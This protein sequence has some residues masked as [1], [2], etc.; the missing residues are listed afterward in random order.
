LHALR[1]TERS[2]LVHKSDLLF[3]DLEYFERDDG[4]V[5]LIHPHTG[6]HNKVLLSEGVV[7]YIGQIL[8]VGRT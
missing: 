3:G 6:G 8:G 1:R 4:P 7:D 2:A 5:S